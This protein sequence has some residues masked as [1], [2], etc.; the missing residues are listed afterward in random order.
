MSNTLDTIPKEVCHILSK[1]IEEDPKAWDSFIKVFKNAHS[2]VDWK[3]RD[4]LSRP[5]W[6]ECCVSDRCGGWVDFRKI[7]FEK[8]KEAIPDCYGCTGVHLLGGGPGNGCYKVR[9]F[10][11]Q[12]KNIL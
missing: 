12:L 4:V 2:V 5:V 10:E 1:Y 8:P 6:I 11:T 3:K 7:H 9:F